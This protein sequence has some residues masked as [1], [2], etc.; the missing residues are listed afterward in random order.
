MACMGY[1]ES[2]GEKE[3]FAKRFHYEIKNALVANPVVFGSA[4]SILW[5]FVIACCVNPGYGGEGMSYFAFD[6]IGKV[7]TGL[8]SSRRTSGS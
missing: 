5:A 3:H 1:E 7:W 4:F 6:W 2:T 8:T